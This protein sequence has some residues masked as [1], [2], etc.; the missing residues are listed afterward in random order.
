MNNGATN[1]WQ[2]AI[3]TIGGKEIKGIK[4]IVYSA[5]NGIV[6]LDLLGAA[7]T[8]KAMH[9]EIYIPNISV[10]AL[11]LSNQQNRLLIYSR[12]GFY[13][14]LAKDTIKEYKRS[15]NQKQIDFINDPSSVKIPD[16][17]KSKFEELTA[18][19][20]QNWDAVVAALKTPSAVTK[21]RKYLIENTYLMASSCREYGFEELALRFEAYRDTQINL[22]K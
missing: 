9:D 19:Y 13:E 22:L 12:E 10:I 5:E 6:K 21:R 18:H 15:F 8:L 7:N 16:L 14:K 4:S 11:S 20:F 1:V 2:D 17:I 3:I